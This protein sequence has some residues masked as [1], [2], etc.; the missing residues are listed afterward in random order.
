MGRRTAA[1]RR[2]P[3]RCGTRGLAQGPATSPSSL[4]PDDV[5]PATPRPSRRKGSFRPDA[6]RA[7]TPA[8][9]SPPSSLMPLAP[10]P[11][12]SALASRLVDL[13][14][15]TPRPPRRAGNFRPATTPPPPPRATSPPPSSKTRPT[16]FATADGITRSSGRRG[17]RRGWLRPRT[18][19]PRSS[20]V[21]SNAFMSD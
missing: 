16:A 11:E 14:P 4:C 18:V 9:T 8:E 6:M 20:P 3:R 19:A 5:R 17:R 12:A 13:H 2:R 21:R 10:P 7:P 1:G 15:S